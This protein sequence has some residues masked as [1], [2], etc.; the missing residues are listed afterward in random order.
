MNL[1]IDNTL[2]ILLLTSLVGSAITDI[3]SQ[4]IPNLITFPTAITALAYHT[5]VHGVD[6]LFFGFGGLALGIGC[7]LPFYLAGGMGAGDA[8]LL[9]SVGAI[10]G[11]KAVLVAALL[12]VIIGGVYAILVLIIRRTACRALIY[13]LTTMFK[14]FLYTRQVIS[15]PASEQENT[16]KLCYGVAIA[17][18]TTLY[19][20]MEMMGYR[21]LNGA[22]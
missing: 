4:R 19:L 2:F 7:F 1:P 10:L 12:T 17:L 5:I 21:F 18:G 11:P 14:T 6:G 8:K 9:G 20:L 13:R 22:I 15:I 16:P 3:K